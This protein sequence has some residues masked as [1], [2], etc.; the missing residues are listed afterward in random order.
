MNGIER[1]TQRIAA[2]AQREAETILTQAQTQAAEIKAA[3]E[4]QAKQETEAALAR[5]KA[6]AEAQRSRL[7][8]SAQ[9]AK[10]QKALAAK[11]EMLDKAFELAL[12][13]LCSLP[14]KEYIDL[15]AQLTVKASSTGCEQLI[16]SRTD[17]ARYGVKVATKANSMLEQA[18]KTARLTLS[19]ESRDFRGG[20]L[21]ADGEVE[22]N[23]T[24]ETLVRLAR[25]TASAE[26]AKVLFA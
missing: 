17:R 26:V 16:L 4:A 23:C 6:Q 15:L 7:V 19:Q 20:L 22:V 25:S 10:G 2:D 5:G 9:M 3:Y 14:D 12:E 13:K 1:I 8:S 21:L 24:F 18:G 11:Q